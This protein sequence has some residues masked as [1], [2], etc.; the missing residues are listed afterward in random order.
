MDEQA[1][2]A[3]LKLIKALLSY[4]KAREAEILLEQSELVDEYLVAQMQIVATNMPEQDNVNSERLR[5]LAIKLGKSINRW[6]QIEQQVI[7]FYNSGEYRSALILANQGLE[8]AITLWGKTHINVAESLNNLANLY[9]A[10]SQYS[11]AK[12]LYEEIFRITKCLLGEEHP[13]VATSLNN[14]AVVYEYLGCFSEAE[15]MYL[16]ALVIWKKLFGEEHSH[17]ATSLNNLASLYQNQRRFNEAEILYETAL[18]MWK[19]LFG[20]ENHDVASCMNNLANLY[21]SLGRYSEAEHLCVQSLEI[22]KRLLGDEHPDVAISLSDLASIYHYQ[23]K[24][25]KSESLYVESLQIKKRLFGNEH[26]DIATNLNN[27]ASLYK[28][29]ARFNEAEIKYLEVLQIRKHLFGDE[30]PD[31]AT[32]LNNLGSIYRDQGRYSEAEH[33][34]V[35]TLKLT[36]HLLGDEH[37]DVAVSLNNLANLYN[38]QRRYNEAEL[39]YNEAFA[40]IKHRLGKEHPYLATCMNNLAELYKSQKRYSEAEKLYLQAIE[41]TQFRFGNDHPNVII[42]LNNLG[43]LLAVTNRPSQAIKQMLHAIT[44]EEKII[45]L[46]FA[47]SCENDR[48]SYLQSIRSNLNGFFSLVYNHLSYCNATK[49]IALDV[50][51]RRKALTATALAVQNQALYSGRYPHLTSEFQQLQSLSEQIV[52]FTFSIPNL[53]ELT[54]YQQNLTRLQDRYN[55]LQRR[56]A[57]QVPEIQLQEQLQTVNSHTVAMKLLESETLVEFV[58][59]RVFDFMASGGGQWQAPRYL[60]FVLSVGGPNNVQ[61]IDLGLAKD[62]DRL[63]LNFRE[64]VIPGKPRN[65]GGLLDFGDWD[66]TLVL[67]IMKCNPAAGIKL[68]EAIFDPIRP[69]LGKMKSLKLAPDGALNLI[70]FEIL[71]IDETG[72]QLLMDKYTISYLSVGRDILRAKVQP[73]RPASAPLVIADPDF[74]LAAEQCAES[75]TTNLP[76]TTLD[77][78]NTLGGDRRFERMSGTRLLGESVAKKLKEVRLYLEAEAVESQ[79]ATCQSPSIL[80]IATHGIFFSDAQDKPPTQELTLSRLDLLS[81]GKIEN[82]MMRSGLALAGA[83]TWLADGSLPKEAGKGFVFAQDVA[84]LDLWA[85]EITVLSACNTAM[86]DIKIGEGV[87]GLRRAFAV[88]GAK[89]LVMSLWPVPDKAT[90]LLMERF[91]DNCDRGLGRAEALQEAQ[92]YL[93]T[94]TVKELRQS[95]LGLEVL[96]DLLGVKEL[97]SQVSISCQEND[98]PLEHPFYWGAWICQGDTTPL[99]FT[100]CS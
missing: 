9:V 60:A 55:A 17:V 91:F 54:I 22:R 94:I 70:P 51:L 11:K 95:S 33:I 14:L 36:K 73:T 68:R 87:F 13:D 52:D 76:P 49:Q 4:P 63:V 89:T 48:L 59:F 25:N 3:Y 80:L 86:G 71:P 90:A 79:L 21:S 2:Q 44:I 88:A 6:I 64:S 47:A 83:N 7:E 20:N 62:I 66:E 5:D 72:K 77:I 15:D 45:S 18:R 92:N 67:E 53:D 98:T 31:V 50:I 74:D 58:L 26:P 42:F 24:Y 97:D 61:M 16:K 29:Q 75:H 1:Q 81:K 12:Y 84:G 30:H 43:T 27:L 82:P 57:S 65:A 93:R 8:L 46:V 32:S 41:I 56:L 37:P 96:K 23:G 39:F 38:S 85:N 19:R 40:I 99:P 78:L 69:Y 10:S 100:A 28:S 35:T 34:Y